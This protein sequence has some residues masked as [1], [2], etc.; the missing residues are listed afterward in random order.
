[1]EFSLNLECYLFIL[2]QNRYKDILYNILS[3]MENISSSERF[4]GRVKWFN[5]KSGYGFISV[6]DGPKSGSDVFVHHSSISVVD[7]N[8][9]KYLVQGEYVEFSF[10]NTNTNNHEF[11]AGDV[12]GINRGKLMCETRND[13]RTSRIN[14]SVLNTESVNL[15]DSVKMPSSISRP[16]ST[17][18]G[19]LTNGDWVYKREIE[20]VS[21][22]PVYRTDTS[23]GSG[24]GAGRGSGRGAGRGSGRG[25]GR[26]RGSGR[27]AGRGSGRGARNEEIIS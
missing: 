5:N 11:Q 21:E 23:S 12:S 13:N 26:G 17:P 22:V 1:M 15:S 7:L 16:Y 27:G 9:Y 3:I 14:Y 20:G 24:R 4:T 19:N 10:S 25:A 6:T 8:Q 2:L 18:R